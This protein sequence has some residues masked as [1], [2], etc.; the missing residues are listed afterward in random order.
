VKRLLAVL[1]LLLVPRT[2]SAFC[3]F[4]VSPGDDKLFADATQV[5]LMRE[6]TRTVLAMQNDYRGPPADF[7]MVV[8]VPVVLQK[9]NV[10]TLAKDLFVRVDKLDSPRLVEYWEED[11][12]AQ[13]VPGG[14]G[15]G[16]TGIG[17]GGGGRGEGIG[18]GSIGS[19]KIEAQFEVGEYEIVILSAKDSSGLDAWLRANNYKIPANAEPVLRPYVQA[20]SKF[21]VAKVN[22]AK[23]TMKDDKAELSPLRFHYDSDKFEL[24]VRLG[25]LNSAGKQDLIVHVLAPSGQRYAV[26]N[27]PNVTIPTN[28]DVAEGTS[29][30]F[31]AFYA[32]LF[33]K[34]IE[35]TPSA[36]VTE[37]VWPTSSCD[38]CPGDVQGL[39]TGELASLG[40]DVLPSAKFGGPAG[41]PSIRQGQ[42]LVSGRLPQE[43]I[44]RIVR[45]NFGRFRACYTKGL[46]SNPTLA[47]TVTVRFTITAQGGV[48][49]PVDAGSTIKD[50]EVVNC[51]VRGFG[52]LS[53][54]QPEAGSVVV[55]YPVIFA[56]PPATGPQGSLSGIGSDF[57]LTRL[58]A[59]YA[60]DSL[61]NDLVFKAAPPIVG[62]RE[63]RAANGTL[64]TGATSARQST[65]QARYAIRHAWTG[66][67]ECKNPIRGVWG[68]PPGNAFG[69]AAPTVAAKLGQVA[70]GSYALG[71]YVPKGVPEL[72]VAAGATPVP[73]T[74][75]VLDAGTDAAPPP[76]A[77]SAPPEPPDAGAPVGPPPTP[78]SRC[79]CRVVGDRAGGAAMIAGLAF[80]A[81]AVVRR[82]REL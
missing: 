74:A 25:M 22:V 78:P 76:V 51:V 71:A 29:D 54:P 30:K 20:G 16:L 65:F 44:Q 72:G 31:G 23:V 5:V 58:H 36:V 2:A 18:L 26:A 8:P 41:A 59:R 42:T 38:P 14:A 77:S 9:E 50:K 61:G 45:Q 49:S 68:G 28:L 43:V 40:A 70:R 34:T 17:E 66:P 67:V 82:R 55:S 52:N 48:A 56:P 57:V 46:S 63:V 81:A 6:G 37:Y 75:A 33:D 3:G 15:L 62:G 12:C 13:G 73:V 80:L 4:Y 19:V 39:S 10:K 21:F 79:G 69:V 53:F 35:K 47:G 27:Y 64:E 1:F 24:P 11:P 60:K 7:A 32:S